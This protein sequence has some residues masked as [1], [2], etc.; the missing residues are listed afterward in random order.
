MTLYVAPTEHRHETLQKTAL[1]VEQS[2]GGPDKG[3]PTDTTEE[4]TCSIILWPIG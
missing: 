2:N 1:L 3:T 4:F